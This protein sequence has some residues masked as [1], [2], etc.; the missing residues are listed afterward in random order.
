MAVTLDASTPAVD[1]NIAIAPSAQTVTHPNITPPAGALLVA[2]GMHDTTPGT[3]NSSSLITSS[4]ALSWT[5]LATNSKAVNPDACDGHIQISYAYADTSTA[6]SITSTGTNTRN[7]CGLA[8]LVF[9]GVPSGEPMAFVIGALS[10]GDLDSQHGLYQDLY[11]TRTD[12][13]C[14]GA[15]IDVFGAQIVTAG[16]NQTRRTYLAMGS[17]PGVDDQ[18]R[19]YVWRQD[20]TTPVAGA[21]VPMSLNE[22]G[23][24]QWA[25]N[26]ICFEVRDAAGT[27]APPKLFL[28]DLP[29]FVG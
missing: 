3:S 19:G 16:A 26:W 7:G 29:L 2:I 20:A 15:Y 5:V 17:N 23:F 14:W 12:S 11:T 9:T 18:P 25:Y 27:A 13:W 8:M 1:S 6:Y 10:N 28:P 22:P 21:R 24:G 4:P